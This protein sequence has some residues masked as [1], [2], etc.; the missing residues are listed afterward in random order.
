MI[1]A[2]LFAIDAAL[3]SAN[4]IALDLALGALIVTLSILCSTR[5]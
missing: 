4:A 3:W 1:T 2:A 5:H